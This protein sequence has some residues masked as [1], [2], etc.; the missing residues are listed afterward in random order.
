MTRISRTIFM[1]LALVAVIA[2]ATTPAIAHKSA[3][4]GH[5]AAP[6]GQKKA[7][8][9][10]KKGKRIKSKGITKLTSGATTLDV[11]ATTLGALT[12]AG[13]GVTP[14]DPATAEGSVFSFPI[15]KGR[16]HLGKGKKMKIKGYVNHKGGMT[17]TLGAVSVSA[18]NL[19]IHLSSS[20]KVRVFAKVGAQRIRLLD[21]SN[22]ALADG[23]LTADAALAEKAAAS[24]NTAFG[25]TLFTKAM[26]MGKVTVTPGA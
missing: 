24:L 12:G 8:K 20:K 6:H 18:V 13:F 2:M 7:G 26:P 5:D 15:S 9:K 4:S 23:K 10:G 25:V 19:R 16:V 22:V 17:F 11:D 3:E 14:A 1:A 21:L